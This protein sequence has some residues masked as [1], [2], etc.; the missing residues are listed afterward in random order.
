MAGK[1]LLSLDDWLSVTGDEFEDVLA[2]LPCDYTA[3]L[4]ESD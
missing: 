2:Q 3:L 1:L 4:D